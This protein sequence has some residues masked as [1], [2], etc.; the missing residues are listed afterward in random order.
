MNPDTDA[1]VWARPTV[2]S[3]CPAAYSAPSTAAVRRDS[4][5]SVRSARGNSRSSATV[6]I[7][8]RT[9]RKSMAGIR[10]VRSLI[11]KN[12]DPQVAVI[13]SSASVAS[14]EVRRSFTR[15]P[16]TAAP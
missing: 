6:A 2:W 8:K 7:G 5:D 9:A 13:A 4:G 3:T 1:A 15:R 12:V 16:P 10:S 11:R 14:R